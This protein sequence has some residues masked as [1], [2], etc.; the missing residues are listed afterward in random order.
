MGRRK[1]GDVA[2][3][4]TFFF[5]LRGGSYLGEFYEIYLCYCLKGAWGVSGF[6]VT[7]QDALGPASAWGGCSQRERGKSDELAGLS[8]V[9][10]VW[11]C[12]RGCVRVCRGGCGCGCGC[13]C[14]RG[15][16]LCASVPICLWGKGW[17]EE[18]GTSV[19][20]TVFGGRHPWDGI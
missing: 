7:I 8:L 18:E 20:G 15:R 4:V 17:G 1:L 5:F 9:G 12:V 14:V 16:C 13:G 6:V 2:A 11:V 10:S 3:I 19:P